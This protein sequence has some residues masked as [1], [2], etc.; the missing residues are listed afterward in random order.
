MFLRIENARI[1][2]HGGENTAKEIAQQ[3]QTLRKLYSAILEREGEIAAFVAKLG[4]DYKI[5]FTGAGS[6]EFAG[7]AVCYVIKHLHPVVESVSTTDIVSSPR[8]YLCGEQKILMVSFGR[9]G[10][11]PESVACVDLANQ[12]CK[13]VCHLIITCNKNGGLYTRF[14]KAPN[15][16]VLLMPEETNDKG[17][18]MTSSVTSMIAA[19]YLSLCKQSV[20]SHKDDIESVSAAMT[21]F[22]TSEH[23][24][25]HE[26]ARS[27]PDRIVFLGSNNLHA[28]VR[29]SA[30]KV[31]ELANGQTATLSDSPMA[32]RHGPKTFLNPA[33]I[34]TAAVMLITNDEHTSRYDMDVLKELHG[35]NRE[36]IIAVSNKP[37][38][39]LAKNSS[40]HILLETKT[41]LTNDIFLSILYL[42]FTQSLAFLLSFYEGYKIDMPVE[43]GTLSRVVS[44]VTIYPYSN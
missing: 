15:A 28:T 29:E 43:S 16:L 23:P 22:L 31:M 9:S 41:T 36:N 34:K 19:A 18:A 8:Q 13:D 40:K 5:I 20:S 17:F 12:L 32:F 38:P 37:Y 6:S 11:S 27:K 44:G 2:E 26:L 14:E 10:D 35:E 25:L 30:L 4:C 3:P 21:D 33:G 1:I 7:Q 42:L 39:G 24:F